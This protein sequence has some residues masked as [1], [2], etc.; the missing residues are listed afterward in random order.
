MTE[1]DEAIAALSVSR[2]LIAMLDILK[3]VTVPTEV[4]LKAAQTDKEL[5]V[6][7]NSDNQTFTFKLKEENGSGFDNNQLIESFE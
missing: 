6:D 1:Q 7:Y 3:E 4:F 2:I 5:Q